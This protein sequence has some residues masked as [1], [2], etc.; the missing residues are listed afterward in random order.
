MAIPTEQLI[1]Y[2]REANKLTGVPVAY[3]MAIAKV[4]SNFHIYAKAKTSSASGIFQFIRATWRMMFA[5]YNRMGYNLKDNPF[6]PRSNII[7]GA[8]LTRDNAQY[9][10]KKAGKPAGIRELYLAHFSGPAKAVRVLRVDP[11]SPTEKI[12]SVSEINANRSILANTSVGVAFRKLTDK[13]H[14][15]WLE[16][17]KYDEQS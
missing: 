5:T 8:F 12:Y 11:N 15:A 4:E 17:K 9:L 16:M 14:K 13:V 2:F 7:L 3:L 6:D 1:G 10:L